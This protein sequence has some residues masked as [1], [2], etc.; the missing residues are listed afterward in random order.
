MKR[1]ISICIAFLVAVSGI[2]LCILVD[3][4]TFNIE[5]HSA[6][7]MQSAPKGQESEKTVLKES[8]DNLINNEKEDILMTAKT[9]LASKLDTASNYLSANASDKTVEHFVDWILNNY[10]SG[11]LINLSNSIKESVDRDF[12]TETGKSLFVLLDEFL[13]IK[14]YDSRQASSSGEIDL[15]FAGDICL[16]EDGF[17]LDY[18]D[19]TTGLKDC[20][21]ENII[22]KTNEADLFMLNNE[23]CFSNRGT[24]LNGKLYTFRAMPERISILNELGTD[25]VSLANNHVY[26]FGPEAFGDTLQTLDNAGIKHV[27]GGN[28]CSEAEKVV[29]Y[30]VNGVKIG[31]ISASSAEKV[32]YTPQAKE[33]SPGI[34]LMYDTTRLYDIVRDVSGRCDYLIAYLHWGTEDS[35]YYEAYQHDIAENLISLGVDAIIGGHPHVLQGLE[36]IS[37]KPVAY[38]LG[39]FWFNSETKYT[40]LVNLKIDIDGIRELSVIPCLQS[41]FTTTLI[42]DEAQKAD[43]MNYLRELSSNCSIDENGVT[44]PIS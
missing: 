34:F 28:N 19:T 32:R 26:D 1:A 13:G 10:G 30:E 2:M 23:F 16:A 35:K 15:M 44:A 20:I 43:F 36:Y 42:E 33:N 8:E 7:V 4:P 18:Y 11:V 3:N 40:V 31:I 24:A 22:N 5:I 37:G 9:N 6:K 38:S 14:D 27:G 41:N 39:D 21:G 17:V 12:Y 25:I 29:Y